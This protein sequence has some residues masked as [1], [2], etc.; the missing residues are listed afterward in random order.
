MV[1][2]IKAMRDDKG[3]MVRN[4]HLIGFFRRICKLLFLRVK[5]VFVFD[6]GTPA[7]KRRTVI[8]RRR[9][10][11]RA[12]S[13][14]RKT[15]EKL[16]LNH[17]RTRK[18]EELA[19]EI[20]IAKGV[21]KTSSSKN[22]VPIDIEQKSEAGC[23]SQTANS[24]GTYESADA[25]LAASLAAE[26]DGQLEKLV[27]ESQEG[28]HSDESEDM[29]GSEEI[30]LPVNQG[31]VDP[32]VL[33]VLP[34][35]MQL[36]L[37]VQM[38]EQLM[39][40]NR[41]KFHKVKKVPASFSE[42]QIQAYLKTVAFRREIEEVRKS[43][44]GR[45]IGGMPTSRIASES[46]REFI[47]S[48]SFTGDKQALQFPGSNTSETEGRPAEQEKA[49]DVSKDPSS[50]LTSSMLSCKTVL[51]GEVSNED[52][53]APVQTYV[54]E[55]G[56]IR[57]S[58]LRGMG[59]RMTRD[60]QWNLYL[61][62]ES[63]EQAM[64]NAANNVNE[65][66]GDRTIQE[67]G[68][69]VVGDHDVIHKNDE[70]DNLEMAD[71]RYEN[72][73][74]CS[75]CTNVKEISTKHSDQ[76]HCNSEVRISRGLQ[77]SFTEDDIGEQGKED[78]FFAALVAGQSVPDIHRES[79]TYNHLED[80]TSECEW[81][82]GVI[83]GNANSGFQG[84]PDSAN[85]Y[86]VLESAPVE[87]SV[88]G[89][90]DGVEW[91]DANNVACETNIP[92]KGDKTK[93]RE[94][95]SEEEE[96][97]EAIRRS[98]EEF[99]ARKSKAT[100]SQL[101]IR[102]ISQG[103]YEKATEVDMPMQI[104]PCGNK[105][106]VITNEMEAK[107]FS[108]CERERKGKA[109]FTEEVDK[110]SEKCKSKLK[111]YIEETSQV[112]SDNCSRVTEVSTSAPEMF[113]V[114]SQFVTLNETDRLAQVEE[115]SR[116]TEPNI[117]DEISKNEHLCH[118]DDREIQNDDR[119]NTLKSSELM[120]DAGQR[121]ASGI[122]HTPELLDDPMH[123]LYEDKVTSEPPG[124]L[125]LCDTDDRE[126]QNDD[127]MNT[128]KSSELI[129]DVGLRV[130][131]S[132]IYTPELLNDPMHTLYQ[133]MATIEPP[134]G[135]SIDDLIRQ[136][137]ETDSSRDREA[138]S[139][140]EAGLLALKEENLRR[141]R[142]IEAELEAEK[143]ALQDN[144][145]EEMVFLRQEELDLQ[146]AQ[147]KHER[148]AESVTGEMF[149]ECQELLQMFGL[150]YIIA[151][152]EAEAQC[153][154]LECT[155]LVE[156]VV[157][158]DCDVFLF[159]AGH[160]YK[161]IFDE[162]KYVETYLMKDI[163]EDLGLDRQKLISMALLLG[164][165]Y[166]EGISGIGI[167]NA[168]EVVRTFHEDDGLKKFKEWVD[169]PDPSLLDKVHAHEGKGSRKRSKSNKKTEHAVE[170]KE[171]GVIQDE[172]AQTAQ[173]DELSED[174]D[175]ALKKIF[176]AKHQAVSKNWHVPDS[177][178]N[179]SV[180]SAYTSPQVD[181]STEPFSWGRPDLMSL[182]KLC[183]ERFGWNKEKA[184]ELLLPVLKEYDRRETQLRLEA[185]YSFNERFAK[186]RSRRIQKAVT[187]ITG[188]RSADLMDLPPHLE[189]TPKKKPRK[190]KESS[191]GATDHNLPEQNTF[192]V[193]NEA[194]SNDLQNLESVKSGKERKKKSDST[195]KATTLG[196]GRG[197]GKG[198]GGKKAAGRGRGRGGQVRNST[199]DSGNEKEKETS[200]K[201]QLKR[202]L[203]A[204]TVGLR[205]STRPHKAVKYAPEQ[206]N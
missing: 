201:G 149:A 76:L 41:Q 60:I 154:Y 4:A 117:M 198:M 159:G 33:A 186:I 167:V 5:P 126:I 68:T 139:E 19:E 196:R 23:S 192:D 83:E 169:S 65:M 62:K 50:S 132:I 96:L 37:L 88:I 160:V 123:T 55:K 69:F 142:E 194:V 180:V 31:K 137:E 49:P 151:P 53:D 75:A 77:I 57:V 30:I 27:S 152:M 6:G 165:D 205:K 87:Y 114:D 21:R 103:S 22:G 147:K 164:S 133:D 20:Q 43:A 73:S 98:L 28:I 110:Y 148:N 156:G 11:E 94:F 124:G 161:N 179:E 40:D 48:S 175:L 204:D 61:M 24:N 115:F 3:E 108:E 197:E 56:N 1:Q 105:L 178:P 14:I 128:L 106:G 9:Q 59:V 47:F 141:K 127:R 138:V 93:S 121:V 39:A 118:T 91:E 183:W 102:D 79:D 176:M 38:R 172:S 13:K 157:T 16:L 80:D 173:E 109:L 99:G 111:G 46:G 90:D 134:G 129:Q 29:D 116:S 153:A 182:R 44:S 42:M 145:D 150:P 120:H 195:L 81:E 54:D 135:L 130:A 7:L 170:E 107:D 85:L 100:H 140:K 187:G 158:D 162:R 52:S 92:S 2:F 104:S 15:A 18:L 25:L 206:D 63:E 70:V 78:D 174:R 168:I 89:G 203:C 131:P 155:H 190:K 171:E 101:V 193:A 66:D 185:F 12:Q 51:Q 119:M 84:H 189:S 58:R 122:I 112:T 199:G 10:R 17:L 71:S 181:K 26:E 125:H 34:P 86:Q 143:E 72:E 45:G 36:D 74:L 184:D 202:K 144:V 177:F 188:R 200:E 113:P 35:S 191:I 8:A 146:A 82:E 97:Q 95:L 64:K 163:E 136:A 67:E 32:A 166:T